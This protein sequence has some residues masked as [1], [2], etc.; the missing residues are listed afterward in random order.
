[1]VLVDTSVWVNHLRMGDSH[2]MHLLEADQVLMHPFVVG[3]LAC[4]SLRQ[5]TEVLGLLQALPHAKVADH[6]EVLS[7]IESRALMSRG[8]GYIDAC[9]LASALIHEGAQIWTADVRLQKIA[10]ELDVAHTPM[11]AG[12]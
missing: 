12:F 3:E 7:F 2:L 6:Q 11:R 9:L 10:M 5:R 4:G 1:M 8:I